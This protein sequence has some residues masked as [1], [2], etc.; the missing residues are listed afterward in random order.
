MPNTPTSK[1]NNKRDT[2]NS[3]IF[4]TVKIKSFK[5][6]PPIEHVISMC[7]YMKLQDNGQLDTDYMHNPFVQTQ[8]I[9]GP[10]LPHNEIMCSNYDSVN[11]ELTNAKDDFRKANKPS[12]LAPSLYE[13]VDVLPTIDGKRAEKVINDLTSI[14][15]SE[16]S[17]DQVVSLIN[18][19]FPT[20]PQYMDVMAL[21]E[22][23]G[24]ILSALNKDILHKECG[25]DLVDAVK[26]VKFLRGIRRPQL[27]K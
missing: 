13:N 16:M 21:N 12:Q 4:E 14:A 27:A 19:L 8:D 17:T 6:P 3:H 2:E 11:A 1:N 23:D 26:L 18:Y 10:S 15:F 7:E 22:V 25:F 5:R 24:V 9:L 20:K